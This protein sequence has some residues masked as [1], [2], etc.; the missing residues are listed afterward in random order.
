[1]AAACFRFNGWGGKYTF[2]DDTVLAHAVRQAGGFEAFDV[3]LVFE[4]GSLEV[5][6]QGTAITTAQCLL[7]PNRNPTLSRADVES[8]I[9]HTG[10]PKILRGTQQALG[11]TENELAASW[12]CL[13]RMGN[14]SSA[15]VLMV[16]E[17]TLLHRRPREGAWSILGAM[18]PG[19]CSELLLLRW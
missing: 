4:G 14:L 1:M 12:A 5:D 15:S 17:E 2:E 13:R 16:L 11:I 7:N 3:P 18:G 6:G 10:G 19:F 9:L 8:W